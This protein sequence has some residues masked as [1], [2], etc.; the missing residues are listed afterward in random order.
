MTS[1]IDKNDKVWKTFLNYVSLISDEASSSG[2][3]IYGTEQRT[4]I[5]VALTQAHMMEH[6]SCEI[7]E[8]KSQQEKFN[9][10]TRQSN[11]RS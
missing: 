9:R 2:M 4:N 1:V 5:A 8:L 7:K 11:L 3:D 6:I 10:L